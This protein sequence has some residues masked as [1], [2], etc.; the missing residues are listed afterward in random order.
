MGF[1][2]GE[3]RYGLVIPRLLERGPGFAQSP[4]FTG[5]KG[6]GDDLPGVVAAVYAGYVGRLLRAGASAGEAAALLAPLDE[7]VGWND[8]P[9][10]TMI[11]NEIFWQLDIDGTTALVEPHMSDALRDLHR[12]WTEKSL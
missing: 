7:F 11:E 1:V 12:R 4:E 8:G 5:L 3:D 10:E 6:T 9:V 2:L